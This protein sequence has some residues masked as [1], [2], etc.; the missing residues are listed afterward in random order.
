M[1]AGR[2]KTDGLTRR[3][4]DM[5]SALIACFMFFFKKAEIIKI[6]NYCVFSLNIIL[7]DFKESAALRKH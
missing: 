5:L 4:R 7:I 2:K 1:Q 3:K 6:T